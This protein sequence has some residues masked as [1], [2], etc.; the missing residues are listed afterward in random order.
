MSTG[1]LKDNKEFWYNYLGY[2]VLDRNIWGTV[3]KQGDWGARRDIYKDGTG[4]W[5]NPQKIDKYG[6]NAD[7]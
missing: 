2:D 1:L 3:R 7:G 5:Q 6:R 4:T